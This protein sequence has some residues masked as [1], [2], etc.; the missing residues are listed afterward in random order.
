MSDNRA[1][2][3]VIF[4]TETTG[5]ITNDLRPLRKQPRILEFAA[6]QVQRDESGEWREIGHMDTLIDPGVTFDPIIT[7]ITGIKP[8]DLVGKPHWSDVAGEVAA[9]FDRADGYAAHNLSFDRRMIAN[10]NARVGRE[11]IWPARAICTVESTEHL[12]GKALKLSDLHEM[13]FGEPHTGAH[14]ALDDVRATA[15]VFVELMKRGEIQ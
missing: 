8:A 14:R 10:E 2:V 12:G 5:L 13:F 9:F 7:K 15:R 6:V 1:P 3:W 4:D 11:T